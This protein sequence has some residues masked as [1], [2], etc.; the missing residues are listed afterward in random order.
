MSGR[1][2][3]GMRLLRKAED[4]IL[5]QPSTEYFANLLCII[6][7]NKCEA[8]FRQG[9]HDDAL[10]AIQMQVGGRPCVPFPHA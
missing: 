10:C 9:L 8:L 4:I 7:E 6:E 1:H 2:E 5:Q 3:E